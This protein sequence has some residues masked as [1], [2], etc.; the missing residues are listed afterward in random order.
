MTKHTR[1]FRD[2]RLTQVLKPANY[3]T[4]QNSASVD[5]RGYQD[6]S[7]L[8][9]VGLSGDTLAVGLYVQLSLQD[10]SDNTNWAACTDEQV[11]NAVTGTVTGTFAKVDAAAEDETA[12]SCAYM[13]SRRY[14]RCV[15]TLVGTHT[16]GVPAAITAI[17]GLSSS[18]R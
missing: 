14:V 13:G 6:L 5:M 3:T 16:V 15:M 2:A 9:S 12:L 1:L 8:A 11:T 18:S 4:S 7:F 17:R 10:S